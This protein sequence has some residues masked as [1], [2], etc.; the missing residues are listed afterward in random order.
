MV[1]ALTNIP[2]PREAD[3]YI[4]DEQGQ[5]GHCMYTTIKSK[6]RKLYPMG[7]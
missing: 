6:Y 7:F 5:L 3:K 1:E 4:A 2:D